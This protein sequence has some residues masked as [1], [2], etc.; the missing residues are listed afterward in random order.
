LDR[1]DTCL[2]I[3]R[4]EQDWGLWEERVEENTWT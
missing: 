2:L 4:E 3:V 1:Y